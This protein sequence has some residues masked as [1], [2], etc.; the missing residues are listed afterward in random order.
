MRFFRVLGVSRSADTGEIRK[1]FASL[2]MTCHPDVSDDP[3]ASS[4][5]LLISEA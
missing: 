1:A 3:S 2:A 4:K 5:F